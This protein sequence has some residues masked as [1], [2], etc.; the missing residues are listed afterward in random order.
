MG[1]AQLLAWG[2]PRF[3]VASKNDARCPV[4]PHKKIPKP[5]NKNP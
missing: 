1:V 3:D 5:K 4:P 2:V